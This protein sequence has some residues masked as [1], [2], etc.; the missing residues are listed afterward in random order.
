VAHDV[1]CTPHCWGFRFEEVK[2]II[3]YQ[4]KVHDVL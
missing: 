1:F 3:L 4:V 2:V